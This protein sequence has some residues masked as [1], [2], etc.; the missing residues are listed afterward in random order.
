VD[1]R[2]LTRASD[3]LEGTYLTR[4]FAEF[5]TGLRLFWDTIQDTNPRA[6]DLLDGLA[7]RRGVPDEDRDNA[8]LV[9]EYRNSLVHEREDEDLEP[10][11]IA[12][13]RS[14]LCTFFKRLPLEWGE[15]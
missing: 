8:H 13:A 7:A 2:D 3:M 4:M 10:I 12:R 1:P 9:R 15:D 5:E 11:P 14:H 6:R